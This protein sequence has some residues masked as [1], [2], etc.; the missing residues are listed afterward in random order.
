MAMRCR[1]GTPL[2]SQAAAR[3]VG[4]DKLVELCYKQTVYHAVF[5]CISYLRCGLLLEAFWESGILDCSNDHDALLTIS[6]SDA[7]TSKYAGWSVAVLP[8]LKRFAASFIASLTYA[9]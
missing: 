4:S 5:I 8:A 3:W 9:V 1:G 7:Q 2:S 6:L